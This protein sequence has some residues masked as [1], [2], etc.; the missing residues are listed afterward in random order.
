M[1][2]SSEAQNGFYKFEF[3]FILIFV[4]VQRLEFESQQ[5]ELISAPSLNL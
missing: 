2:I 3:K 1:T 5:Y 4:N